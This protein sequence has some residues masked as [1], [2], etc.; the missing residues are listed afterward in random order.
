MAVMRI[1]LFLLLFPSV[2]S[3]VE[4]CRNV[5]SQSGYALVDHAYKSFFTG[6]LASCYMSCNSL[7]YNLADKTCEL[8][9]DTK[10]FRPKYFVKKP[11]FVYAENP[12]S[13]TPWRKLNSAPVC[14]GAKDNQFGRFQVEIGGSIQAI[15][16]VHLSG[17]VTCDSRPISRSNW[18]CA[19][20]H[21][22]RNIALFLTNASNT[23]LL[24]MGQSSPYTIPG[25]DEQSSEIVFSGFPNPLHLSSDKELRLW[26]SEDLVDQSEHDN[27]GTSCT[28][29]F[30]K[31]L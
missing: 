19:G 17:Y 4:S 12:D 24:P 27:G 31:Y 9:N 14:F 26:Y 3:A 13:E 2:T 8:N 23:I 30:A 22:V 20:Q 7:N 29:V 18:G 10:Y 21:R 11:T 25:Y 5:Y 6:R 28:D 15:K 16:L 1:I